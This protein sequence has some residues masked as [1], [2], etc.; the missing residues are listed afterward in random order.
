M[1]PMNAIDFPLLESLPLPPRA[2]MERARAVIA[3]RI[4]FDYD[5]SVLRSDARQVLDRK[6]DVLRRYPDFRIRI[7]GHADER[8]SDEYN[9]ALG[10]RR[11]SA[12]RQYLT[13]RGLAAGRFEAMSYGEERPVDRRSNET[14]WAANRR[15]EFQII[16]GTVSDRP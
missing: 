11:A 10:M 1:A 2:E 12:A 15:A 7:E 9:I 13:E 5:Q 3:E 8:G 16:S 4:H 14:A 6:V